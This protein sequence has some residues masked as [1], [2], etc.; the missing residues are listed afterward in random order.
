MTKITYYTLIS[1][2]FKRITL[3][4]HAIIQF[5]NEISKSFEQ[6]KYTLGIF[7][8]L[9]KAFDTV[10]HRILLQKLKY[11]GINKQVLRW[12]KSYLSNRK[13]F[14]IGNDSYQN[15][16]LNI[17]CGVPQG[18]ILGPLLFLIYINDL[19]KATNLMSI[20]FAD[21]T[22]LFVSKSDINELFA[23]ANKELE[24]LS[25]WFKSNKLTL[26][27][28]KTKW[29]LFHS[30]RKKSSLPSNLP[31]ILIDNVEIKRDPVTKFLGVYLDENITWNQHI[32]Y[33]CSKVSK[34]MGVLYKARNYLNKINLRQLYFSFIHCYLNYA[35]I[36]WGSTEKSKL[37]RLYRCQK[38]AIRIINFA[39]RFSHCKPYFIEMRILNI[40][41]LNV[42]KILCFVYM[43]KNNISPPVF[44]DFLN[45]KPT[46]KYE[47]R[48]INFLE[49][50]FCHTNF[51]Q[52]CLAY[53][54][55]HLWNK[56]VLPNFDFD[57]TSSLHLFK[58]KAKSFILSQNNILQYF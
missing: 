40:Y 2:V 30:L 18:S 17:T 43:W 51:N 48:N 20:M 13:Q 27:T 12:F 8:D 44:K 16:C 4:E 31:Q 52:F 39:D 11:Y 32:S 19:N 50:P 6:S 29:I 35:N 46:N 56:L 47:L 24:H 22:N 53:R 45:L 38:R 1:L 28:E 21:D 54:A 41:E 26:N 9:S 10:N 3:M 15:N 14:V 58:N 57:L 42:L 5:V 33:I 23:T 37:Q 55:P 34:N 7:I 36:A 49:K 25:H